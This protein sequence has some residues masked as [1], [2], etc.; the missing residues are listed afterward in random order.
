MRRGAGTAFRPRQRCRNV[1]LRRHR[2]EASRR[3]RSSAR[4]HR[5]SASGRYGHRMSAHRAAPCVDAQL[6]L[7]MPRSA[8][9]RRTASAPAR[10]PSSSVRTTW[11]TRLRRGFLR[12]MV[13]R[14]W[15][16]RAGRPGSGT[17]GRNRLRPQPVP[18]HGE[19]GRAAR[20]RSQNSW[21]GAQ[22]ATAQPTDQ[23]E[24]WL[25]ARVIGEL[26]RPGFRLALQLPDVQFPFGLLAQA[27]VGTQALAA[28]SGG[29]PALCSSKQAFSTS[30]IALA[31]PGPTPGATTVAKS[32]AVGVDPVRVSRELAQIGDQR[33]LSRRPSAHSAASGSQGAGRT[34]RSPAR[35][36]RARLWSV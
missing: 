3:F 17:R 25:P 2:I 26:R 8:R 20:S 10:A 33:L 15:R 27:H 32:S 5:T 13:S 18:R 12:E 16:L 22:L 23:R 14:R 19:T 7:S 29:G 21:T 34:D 6:L 28:R 35:M 9:V 30:T 11:M 36:A 4:N 31:A 1:H 24:H